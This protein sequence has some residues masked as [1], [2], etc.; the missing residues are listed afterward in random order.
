LGAWE[1]KPTKG[2]KNKDKKK[3]KAGAAVGSTDSAA[4][5]TTT[6]TPKLSSVTS[7]PVTTPT[8]NSVSQ[9]RLAA[10]KQADPKAAHAFGQLGEEEK[11]TELDALLHELDIKSAQIQKNIDN[12]YS[13]QSAVISAIQTALNSRDRQLVEYLE[14]IRQQIE[15]KVQQQ[16]SN[17]QKLKQ[18]PKSADEFARVKAEQAS[19]DSFLAT[20]FTVHGDKA[21]KAIEKLGSSFLPASAE[22]VSYSAPVVQAN[23]SAPKNTQHVTS[24]LNGKP[25]QSQKQHN[26]KAVNKQLNG[27]DIKHSVSHSSLVSEEE[28]D[29]GLGQISPVSQGR[30]FKKGKT[31]FSTEKNVAQVSDGGFLFAS[32]GLNADQL[33]KLKAEVTETLKAQGIDPS[34]LAS[35][36]SSDSAAR[37]RN[38][39]RKENGKPPNKDKKSIGKAVKS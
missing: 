20:N 37:P 39:P 9:Q 29:S 4:T 14:A 22:A 18:N 25:A 10:V 23:G 2:K 27:V 31:N 30:I 26:G 32:D 34:I 33:A 1:N 16:R 19:F 5:S 15:S 12:V 35:I 38:R 13:E 11:R 36:S 24:Q 8:S 7:R 3:N 17:I 28:N 6:E 21:I